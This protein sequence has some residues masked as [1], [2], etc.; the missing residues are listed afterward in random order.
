MT[1]LDSMLKSRD[2][3]LPTKVHLVEMQEKY[4]Q[5]RQHIKKQRHYFAKKGPSSQSYGLSNSHVWMWELDCKENW[6]PKN[7][8]FWT[9]VLGKTLESPLDCKLKAGNPKGNQSW[10]FI[11]RTDA[12]AEIPILWPPDVKNQLIEKYPNAGKDWGQEE[13]GETEDEMV[14]W[15]HHWLIGYEF[16]KTQGDSEGQGSLACCSPRGHK[17][18]DMT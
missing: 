13:K 4:D 8:C 16:E 5:P 10:I 6:V 1:N 18:L 17:E 11:E 15:C 7:W 2:I 12:E 9:M 3:T 14:G